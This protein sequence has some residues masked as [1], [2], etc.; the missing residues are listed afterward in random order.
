MVSGDI[1]MNRGAIITEDERI[2]ILNWVL[3]NQSSFPR[4]IWSRLSKRV[5]PDDH[6]LIHEIKKRIIEREGL[7]DNPLDETLGDFI[8][9][10]EPGGRIHRH[11]DH[12]TKCFLHVRFNVFIQLPKKGCTTYYNNIPIQA[13]EGCYVKS[14]SGVDMHYSDVNEDTI[15][16]IGLS[17]GFLC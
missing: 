2:S 10:V 13:Q 9:V 7:H 15:P 17:Y 16:R 14:L 3:E 4:I 1:V 8:S 6:E 12:N 5:T 11:R